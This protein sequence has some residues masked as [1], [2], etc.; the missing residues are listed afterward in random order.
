MAKL[1]FKHI[2]NFNSIIKFF[3]KKYNT[4]FNIILNTKDVLVIRNYKKVSII[5]HNIIGLNKKIDLE[6]LIQI[7]FIFKKGEFEEDK[8]MIKQD[9]ICLNKDWFY[10]K[11]MLRKAM[12]GVTEYTI[13]Y[14]TENVIKFLN[15]NIDLLKE[16]NYNINMRNKRASCYDNFIIS[17][18]DLFINKWN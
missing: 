9:C 11:E 13:G 2:D 18:R 15:S 10:H 8:I 3:N 4:F 6:Y 17:A 7:Q 12:V 16:I 1:K 5:Q 14:S